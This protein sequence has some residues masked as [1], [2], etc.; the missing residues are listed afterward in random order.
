[1]DSPDGKAPSVMVIWGKL[2]ALRCTWDCNLLAGRAKEIFC[3][4]F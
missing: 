2:R 3:S 1:M 4:C